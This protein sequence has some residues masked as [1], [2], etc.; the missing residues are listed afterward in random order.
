M[1]TKTNVSTTPRDWETVAQFSLLSVNEG[2]PGHS[3]LFSLED[4][5]IPARS[6]T[7]PY[8]GHVGVEVPTRFAN[9]AERIIFGREVR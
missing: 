7:S 2:G 1:K 4:A 8:V 5:K 9:R 6:C 3:V